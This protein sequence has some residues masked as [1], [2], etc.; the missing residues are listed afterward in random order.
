MAPFGICSL[1]SVFCYLMSYVLF[2]LNFCFV[3][4]DDILVY[5]MSWKEHLQHLQLVFEHLKKESLKIKLSKCQFFKKHLHYLGHLIWEK[6]IQP[7]PEKVTAFEKLKEPSNIDKLH[8]FLC[9][10]GYYRK[11]IPLFTNI[12]KPLNKLLKKDTNFISH[13]NARQHLSTLRKYF[14]KTLYFSILIQKGQTPYFLTQVTTTSSY[15]G[16]WKSWWSEAHSIHIRL[17][18]S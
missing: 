16:S 13:H 1:S 9:L 17:I 15:S 12:T 5:N 2:G 6:G 11:F 14:V 4:F 8:H 18:L 7:I 10:E 3:Y